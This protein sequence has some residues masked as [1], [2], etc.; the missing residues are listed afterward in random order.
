MQYQVFQIQL[1][2]QEYKDANAG[3]EVQK[4]TLQRQMFGKK[5]V[6]TA[7]KAFALG[8]YDHVMNI[9]AYDLD[10]VF[11]MGNGMMEGDIEKTHETCSSISVGDI[12]INEYDEAFVVDTFG[13]KQISVK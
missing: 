12:I 7:K 9:K 4:F 6:E 1:T 11:A 13:F 3:V 8:C 5:V 10:S 2:E